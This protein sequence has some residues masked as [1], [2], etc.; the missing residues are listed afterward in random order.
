MDA[1]RGAVG[2]GVGHGV[3]IPDA[4]RYLIDLT[5]V[6]AVHATGDHRLVKALGLLVF[7]ALL[8]SAQ[9][10]DQAPHGV[11]VHRCMLAWA[12]DKADHRIA[13]GWIAVKKVLAIPIE[14]HLGE[15]IR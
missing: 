4:R 2:Q 3:H 6:Q 5:G 11:V 15:C 12:P 14:G 8:G 9:H 1:D 13:L 7:L 10:T